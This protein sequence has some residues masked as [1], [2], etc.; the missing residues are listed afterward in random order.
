[1][2]SPT[3]TE[4]ATAV[5]NAVAAGHHTREAIAA[6]M[7]VTIPVVNGSL[8]SL[9]RNGLVEIDE[10]DGAVALTADA[11]PFIT[12]KKGKAAAAAKPSVRE[13]TKMEAARQLFN[14]LF[15]KGRQAVLEAFR[16]Q[17]GLT[18]AG[19][20]TYYQTLRGQAGMTQGVAFSK[21][22]PK[23]AKKAA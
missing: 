21:K 18:K 20:V 12:A 10:E 11:K 13:G 22:T 23:R 5:L 1:M 15:K 7:N 8:T 3:I 6:A 4:K 2:N 16:E 9:K 17:V 14:S 19:A